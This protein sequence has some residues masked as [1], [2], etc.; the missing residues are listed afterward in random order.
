[1]SNTSLQYIAEV[2]IGDL[3]RRDVRLRN[4]G[5]DRGGAKFRGGD[6]EECTVEL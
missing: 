1:L 4:G 5:F 6:C 2:H 3:G